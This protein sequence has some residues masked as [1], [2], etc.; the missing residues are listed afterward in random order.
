MY[1]PYCTEEELRTLIDTLGLH[2]S[3]F[4]FS[5]GIAKKVHNIQVRDDGKPYLE[6]HIFPVTFS[7]VEKCKHEE[8]LSDV[9]IISILH[10]VLEDSMK[11]DHE[12]FKEVLGEKIYN[13]LK[14]LSKK[15][16][17]NENLTQEEKYKRNKEMIENL[18]YAPKYIRIIKLEDRL[19]NL[20][21]TEKV[22]GIPKY[23]RFIKETEDF[24]YPLADSVNSEY[25]ELL[26]F[27]ID[28]L[29]HT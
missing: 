14:L 29:K 1:K 6:Q 20:A 18:R 10:D 22:S 8:F 11:I 5:M 16:T 7:V 28:R 9:L 26:K 2:S 23:S 13:E 24:F 4:D 3:T 15:K 27:Q 21:C 25:K 17:F 19:N 12:R